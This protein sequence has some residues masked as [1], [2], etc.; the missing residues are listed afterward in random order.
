V[1]ESLFWGFVASVPLM[2]GALL[3]LFITVP[4]SVVDTILAFGSGVL[5][6]ALS[7]SLVEEAFHL[8]KDALPV[9]IGFV[10]GG[11]SYTTANFILQVQP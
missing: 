2:A 6:A 7:F 3:P 4:K 5:V 8:T 9:I 1:I 11:I 10:L